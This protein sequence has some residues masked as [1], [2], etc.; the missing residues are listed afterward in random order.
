MR[1]AFYPG[2]TSPSKLGLKLAG[3]APPCEEGQGQRRKIAV[4][5]GP[6]PAHCEGAEMSTA[7]ASPPS[8]SLAPQGPTRPELFDTPPQSRRDKAGAHSNGPKQRKTPA[9][10]AAE[11][12]TRKRRA[13]NSAPAPGQA[14]TLVAVRARPTIESERQQQQ[15]EACITVNHAH[16]AVEISR[17][18]LN[19]KQYAFDAVFDESADTA[20]VYE[21]L[22]QPL[23]PHVLDG[24][25]AVVTAYGQ[26][27]TG[28]THTLGTDASSINSGC[29]IRAC[30]ALLY[31]L[32]R[33][34]GVG[35]GGLPPPEAH[36]ARV[37]V[38]VVELYNE[39]LRDLLVPDSDDRSRGRVIGFDVHTHALKGSSVHQIS[40]V[41]DCVALIRSSNRRRA[42]CGCHTPR[43]ASSAHLG[44]LLVRFVLERGGSAGDGS[45]TNSLSLSD[46]HSCHSEHP[47]RALHV[48]RSSLSLVELAG[49]E[50][51]DTNSA[52]NT[53]VPGGRGIEDIRQISNALSSLSALMHA[54]KN[55]LPLY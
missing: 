48:V 29:L 37:Y 43:A 4:T 33:R 16:K 2:I 20:Q 54:R 44:H 19:K 55:H 30:T 17:S 8:S 52:R 12:E 34:G 32:D 42:T 38:S 18:F 23:V 40:S 21:S 13:A 41:D 7:H 14:R 39:E 27:A 9:A 5:V 49:S 10:P 47:E 15:F 26:S 36:P 51:R 53:H 11:P 28:K 46:T 35:A 31:G 50:W 22:V 6:G 45:H 25:S 24:Y 3:F 1:H